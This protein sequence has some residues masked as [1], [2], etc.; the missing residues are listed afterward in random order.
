MPQKHVYSS[1]PIEIFRVRRC[2]RAR[3]LIASVG[4]SV[5]LTLTA[6]CSTYLHNPERATATADIKTKFGRLSA[7]AY[8]EA[9]EKNLKDFADREDRAVA[10]FLVA[11]RDY[12][13]LNVIEPAADA[14]PVLKQA[15]R[16]DRFIREDLRGAIGK[17]Q[18]T[19]AELQGFTTKRTGARLADA[20]IRTNRRQVQRLAERYRHVLKGKLPTNCEAVLANRMP[21]HPDLQ[22]QQVYG[23]LVNDC[24]RLRKRE[25]VLDGCQPAPAG[26]ALRDVCA[27]IDA[28]ATEKRDEQRKRDLQAAEKTLLKAVEAKADP[29]E[30]QRAQAFIDSLNDLSTDERLSAILTRLDAVFGSELQSS[31]EQ[32]MGDAKAG[33][34][35]YSDPVMKALQLFEAIEMVSAE[36][37][38]KAAD[39][40]S[41]LLIGLAKVRHDLNVVGI[42]IAAREAEAALLRDQ[43]GSLHN[44]IYFLGEAQAVLALAKSDEALNHLLYSVNKGHIPY[45]V[46]EFRF[47]Q[48][49][50]ATAVK[51]AKVTEADYR[52]L[53]QPAIDQLAAYGAGGIKPET[54][55]DLLSGLPAAIPL[56]EE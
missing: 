5:V 38:S 46:A 17:E 53:L 41:A 6:G 8:F 14:D 35:T 1:W 31:V 21:S 34:T 45:K 56:L 23:R 13:L 22:Q 29:T 47:I 10:E 50:R 3:R 7:P 28:L 15:G 43:V 2:S 42:D 4:L 26:G 39:K 12:R 25:A 36:E 16:L 52:V 24:A 37:Q 18:L 33:L 49:Q 20:T 51:H 19:A 32:M 9:Q 48:L 55:A 27:R 30:V 54:I 11:S 44:Q 40:S